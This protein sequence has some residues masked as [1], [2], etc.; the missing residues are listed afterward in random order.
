MG[1][2]GNERKSCLTP[3]QSFQWLGM[4][5]DSHLSRVSLS[6]ANVNRIISRLHHAL[7]AKAFT[8]RKW[9]VLIGS[10]DFAAEII[11]RGRLLHRRLLWEGNHSLLRSEGQSRPLP[12]QSTP[13]LR[14]WLR[15]GLLR[16][17]VP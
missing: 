7:K 2:A 13:L 10:L 8:R 9:E 5:W 6:P 16:A 15:Q 12:G 17:S 3:S 14:L 4:S 1:L 11:P